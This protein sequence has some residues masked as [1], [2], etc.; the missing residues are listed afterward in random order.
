MTKTK[1][2]VKKF[3]ILN[4]IKRIKIHWYLKKLND[5]TLESHKK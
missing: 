5:D 2:V 4:Y 1:E 3:K